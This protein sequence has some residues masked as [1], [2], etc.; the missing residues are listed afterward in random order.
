MLV[1][2]SECV[3]I[4]GRML[5][6]P[7]QDFSGISST[8][9]H[10]NEM[11][12]FFNIFSYASVFN[13]VFIYFSFFSAS[14]S[15]FYFHPSLHNLNLSYSLISHFEKFLQLQIADRKLDVSKKS[16]VVVLIASS[17]TAL[18]YLCSSLFK[19][20]SIPFLFYSPYNFSFFFKKKDL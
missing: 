8:W 10:F 14:F 17:L 18:F 11:V 19:L 1:L 9:P 6:E 15:F 7:V 2:I 4:N 3:K 13:I 5:K 20:Y 16:V 12:F